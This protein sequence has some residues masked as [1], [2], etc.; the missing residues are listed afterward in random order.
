MKV[1][2]IKFRIYDIIKVEA[3]KSMAGIKGAGL[4]SGW[5]WKEHYSKMKI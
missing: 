2:E 5:G 1:I 3:S 4:P